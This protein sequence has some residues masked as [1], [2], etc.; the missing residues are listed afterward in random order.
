MIG[1]ALLLVLADSIV[2]VPASQFTAIEVKVPA[3]NTIVDGSFTVREGGTRVQAI[4][5]D[6]EQAER[7]HRGRSIRPVYMSAYA[8]R[9]RFRETLRDAGDY[10]LILDNRLE[11][12]MATKVHLRLDVSGAR[13]VLVTELPAARRHAVVALSLLFF[14][15]TVALTAWQFLRGA[16]S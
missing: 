7:F 9:D 14:G 1:L 8:G 4:L 5:L 2:I 15:F 11:G 10:V 13:S 16:S 3:H 6:R 12:R